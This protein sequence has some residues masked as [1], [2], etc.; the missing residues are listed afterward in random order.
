MSKPIKMEVDTST[1]YKEDILMDMLIAT[2][3]HCPQMFSV[4]LGVQYER[5]ESYREKEAR[6]YPIKKAVIGKLRV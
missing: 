1:V 5:K 2:D 6:P 3:C 4:V